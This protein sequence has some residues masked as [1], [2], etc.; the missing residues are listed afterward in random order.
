MLVAVS[1]NLA[2]DWIVLVTSF[3]VAVEAL[4]ESIHEA[5][6]QVDFMFARVRSAPLFASFP[7]AARRLQVIGSV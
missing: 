3:A 2:L 5:L 7:R 1:L 6:P 4:G